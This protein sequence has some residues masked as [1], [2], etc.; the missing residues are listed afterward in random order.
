EPLLAISVFPSFPTATGGARVAT[1]PASKADAAEQPA[2][3]EQGPL[4]RGRLIAIIIG[5]I[6]GLLMAALDQTILATAVPT[7]ADDLTGP[8]SFSW[9]FTTYRLGQTIAM[10]L[11]GK[12]GDIIGRK[13]AFHVAIVIFLAGSVIAG[14]AQS[15]GMLIVSRAVQ[16][17]GAG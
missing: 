1:A 7:L 13:L 6:I 5:L 9:S 14:L 2:Q 3:A 10:P 15:M 17:I 12:V 11:W 16:G 8:P 4:S